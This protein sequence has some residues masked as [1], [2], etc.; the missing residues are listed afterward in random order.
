MYWNAIEFQADK[1]LWHV[2]SGAFRINTAD[3]NDMINFH[4]I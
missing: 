4:N 2:S 1:V 3:F